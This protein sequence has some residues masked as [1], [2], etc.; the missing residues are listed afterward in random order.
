MSRFGESQQE[1]HLVSGFFLQ[2]AHAAQTCRNLLQDAV[3][4]LEVLGLMTMLRRGGAH[5]CLVAV[6]QEYNGETPPEQEE[7]P[8]AK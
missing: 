3:P 1:L 2:A 7:R 6:L 8:D 4:V 5:R